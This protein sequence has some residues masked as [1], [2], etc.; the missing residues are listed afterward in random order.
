MTKKRKDTGASQEGMR[1]RGFFKLQIC[2]QDGRVSGDS[3][4]VENTITNDG[5]DQ[6]LCRSLAGI[7]GSKQ[8]TYAMI[9]TGTA[10]G[11]TGTSLPGEITDVANARCAVTPS[12][13]GSKTVQ[14]AFTLASGIY[15]E[16]KVIQ[17][18]G[19]INHSSTSVAGTIF[20]GNTYATSSLQTNQSINASYQIRMS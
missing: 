9:G 20:A 13:I 19:L 8:V 3:G 12:V 6:Y 17:N 11:A 4:W 18:I 2:E 10:P 14:F 5:F 1:A 7:T 15:T 16:S